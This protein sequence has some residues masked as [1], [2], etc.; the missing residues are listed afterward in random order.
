MKTW[1]PSGEHRLVIRCLLCPGLVGFF[2]LTTVPIIG[3]ADGET[4]SAAAVAE[5]PFQVDVSEMYV[6]VLNRS[7]LGLRDIRVTIIPDGQLRFTSPFVRL[8]PRGKRVFTINEFRS[9]DNTPLSLRV[10]RPRSV[11]V[12]ATDDIG[13]P[14]RLQVPW[15][16]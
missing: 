3:C 15:R 6:T 9:Q 7:S 11:S 14:H 13:K 8:A 2:L 12:E 10:V 1:S 4:T 16:R 5:S